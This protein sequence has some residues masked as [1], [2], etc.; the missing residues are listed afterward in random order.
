MEWS[1]DFAIAQCSL[2]ISASMVFR[3]GPDVEELPA[4]LRPPVFPRTGKSTAGRV[5]RYPADFDCPVG[6][7]GLSPAG[8]F[9]RRGP[10]VAPP[11]L[12]KFTR[13]APDLP[14]AGSL[15]AL[16]GSV[17]GSGPRLTFFL[18]D[19]AAAGS[20]VNRSHEGPAPTTRVF[21]C[22]SYYVRRRMY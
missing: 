13:F 7:C 12:L 16:L 17:F 5:T 4:T 11:P 19:F 9:T 14:A 20:I 21:F 6:R 2:A 3:R 15:R 1:T 10:D 8:A 22:S 18:P